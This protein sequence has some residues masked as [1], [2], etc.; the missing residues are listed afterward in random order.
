[1]RSW[2][3]ISETVS[4]IQTNPADRQRQRHIIPKQKIFNLDAFSQFHR[5]L[6]LQRRLLLACSCSRCSPVSLPDVAGGYTVSTATV[7]FMP[8]TH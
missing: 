7:L 5:M 6:R 8:F 2:P 1:M 4:G 3:L